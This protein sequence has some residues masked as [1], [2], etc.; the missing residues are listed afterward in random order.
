MFDRLPKSSF[1]REDCEQL[2]SLLQKDLVEIM[3]D[4]KRVLDASE[5]WTKNLAEGYHLSCSVC[6]M[7]IVVRD[8]CCLSCFVSHCFIRQCLF[9]M[10]LLSRLVSFPLQ[11][12]I[13]C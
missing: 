6:M 7:E 4:L 2:F 11:K 10:H 12:P 13:S 3:S 8:E 9:M 1:K 5:F